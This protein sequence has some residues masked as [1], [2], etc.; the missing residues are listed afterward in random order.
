MLLHEKERNPSRGLLQV[1]CYS[2][3][4]K[5]ERLEKGKSMKQHKLQFCGFFSLVYFC[6]VFCWKEKRTPVKGPLPGDG[7]CRQKNSKTAKEAH[8][9]YHNIWIVFCFI[10]SLLNIA[11]LQVVFFVSKLWQFTVHNCVRFRWSLLFKKFYLKK[12]SFLNKNILK[13]HLENHQKICTII[14][15]LI[16][17]YIDNR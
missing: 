5:K 14:D 12:K 16:D 10:H 17:R 3:E 11:C 13:R 1:L 2:R 15:R 7:G 4:G 9:V 8:T 6:L